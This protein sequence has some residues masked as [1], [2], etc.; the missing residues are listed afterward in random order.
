MNLGFRREVKRCEGFVKKIVVL[1]LQIEKG[2]CCLSEDEC[3]RQLVTGQSESKVAHTAKRR[4][5]QRPQSAIWECVWWE[6]CP[7]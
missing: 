2:K 5:P 4:T 3:S 6:I 7:L 1:A